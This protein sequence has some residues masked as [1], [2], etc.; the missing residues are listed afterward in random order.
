MPSLYDKLRTANR[1]AIESTLKRHDI[2]WTIFTPRDGIV[3]ALDREPGWRRLDADAIAVGHVPEASLEGRGRGRF[4]GASARFRA[5]SPTLADTLFDQVR[6]ADRLP[7]LVRG[8][9]MLGGFFGGRSGREGESVRPI[10]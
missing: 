1:E 2:A 7:G 6:P 8:L 10:E 5:W 3:G 9:T 4:K